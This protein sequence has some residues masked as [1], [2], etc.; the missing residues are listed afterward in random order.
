MGE[1]STPYNGIAQSSSDELKRKSLRGGVVAVCGQGAR[2]LLQ[3][4]TTM[5]LARLLSAEDFGLQG[6]A[7][8]LISFL[9]L[10]SDGGLGAATVQ[11]SEVTEEQISTLFW[12]NAG[13]GGALAVI[14]A[15]LAPLLV[16]FYGEPR[17]YWIAVFLGV[18][19]IFSGLAAQHRALIMR[20]M[21]FA[22]LT[23]ID[24]LSLALSSGAGVVAALLG[25]HYWALVVMWVV[26]SMVGAIGVW[27]AV[28][29]IPGPPRRGCGV[30]SLLHF[31]WMSSCSNLLVFLAWNAENILVGRFWGAD[32]LGL[33]GRAY[34]LATMPIHQLNGAVSSVAFSALSR[35]QNDPH[36]LA[37][38]FLR[39]FSIVVSLTVPVTICCAL[40]AEEIVVV[41]L[42]AKWI[43]A[44]PIFRLLAPTAL[45]FA[46]VNPMSWLV[47]SMGR[48]GRA[49]SLTAATTPVVILGIVLGLGHG[50]TGVALG[51]S[52]AMI[53]L[54]LPIVAWSK[55]GTSITWADLLKATRQPLLSGLLASAAGLIVKV[56]LG[57]MLAPLPYLM[58][59]VSVV[60]G[61]YGWVLLIAMGQK[62][63]Y[64]DLL[65]H[66]YRNE[67]A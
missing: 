32:A 3:T 35:M 13:V 28:P 18:A 10:F 16:A 29:W 39:G 1:L 61:V 5:L 9:G 63:L 20:N 40:F 57:G 66:A 19:F 6:M 23:K 49:L 58:V 37:R 21:R 64:V 62:H 54:V 33:Y 11:R 38:S 47:T 51:Y 65:N 44:A 31:G 41:L 36:R 45:V 27:L 15:A 25:W 34:Q 60:L 46:L 53:L 30:L 17:L 12:I 26:N 52:S 59:G 4:A 56:T 2:F 42:G 24:V 14:S 67:P 8:V 55:R 43:E 48:M 22:T 50:P 7:A